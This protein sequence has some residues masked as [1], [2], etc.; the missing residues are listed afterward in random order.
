MLKIGLPYDPIILLLGIYPRE[1][2]KY[3]HEE[4][5]TQILLAELFIIATE[6]KRRDV[7]GK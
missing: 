7:D 6:G 2:K 5:L 4:T 3:A 1:L